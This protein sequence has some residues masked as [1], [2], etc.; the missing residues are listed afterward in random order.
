[1]VKKCNYCKDVAI[2]QARWCSHRC[3]QGSVGQQQGGRECVIADVKKAVTLHWQEN[4]IIPGSKP[5]PITSSIELPKVNYQA[6]N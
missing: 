5:Q 1:M 6:R 4:A 3:S 2:A